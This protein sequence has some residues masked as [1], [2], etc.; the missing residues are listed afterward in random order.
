MT[1]SS[2]ESVYAAPV[3]PCVVLFAQKAPK[4]SETVEGREISRSFLVI[5]SKLLLFLILFHVT[6][7]INKSEVGPGVTAKE[8]FIEQDEA[9]DSSSYYCVLERKSSYLQARRS[10]ETSDPNQWDVA[11]VGMYQ[12]QKETEA[13][14]K[15]K[16]VIL[17]FETRNGM[18]RILFP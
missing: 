1:S 14:K 9:V 11:T 8:G 16:H 7:C 12:R 4:L 15:V 17:R 13:I 2:K 10:L 18:P 3:P 5:D 6:R